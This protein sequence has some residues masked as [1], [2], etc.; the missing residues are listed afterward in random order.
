MNNSEPV[1]S[2]D[3]RRKVRNVCIS[4]LGELNRK[5]KYAE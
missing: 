3:R 2:V 5:E 4:V 1:R